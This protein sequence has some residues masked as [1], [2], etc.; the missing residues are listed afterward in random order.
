MIG[1][2]NFAILIY[3]EFNVIFK[4]ESLII[5]NIGLLN[6]YVKR[7]NFLFSS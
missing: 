2:Y 3:C 1:R 6:R 7:S 5:G 4:V